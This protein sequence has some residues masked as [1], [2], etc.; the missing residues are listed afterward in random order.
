[1]PIEPLT[2]KYFP[3]F[4]RFAEEAW[5]RAVSD[6][7]YQWRY[8]DAP[9]LITLVANHGGECV[10]S[11]SAFSRTY[12]FGDEPVECLDPFDWYS[13]PSVR[14]SGVG[15]RLIKYLMDVGKPI[16]TL[17]GSADTLQII[18]RLGWKTVSEATEF[19]LPLTSRYLL[20][21]RRLPNHWNRAIAP[22]LDFATATWFMPAKPHGASN[23]VVLPVSG[24]DRNLVHIDGPA[25]FRSVPDPR[26]FDWLMKGSPVTGTYI[27]MALVG[28]QEIVAWI[29]GRL[30]RSGGL[31]HGMILDLRLQ[32]QDEA[33]AESAIKYMARALAGFGADHIRAV[34]TFGLFSAAYRRSGFLAGREKIPVMM[35]PESRKLISEQISVSGTADGA[36]WPL[37]EDMTQQEIH[38]EPLHR[39][40]AG[41]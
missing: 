22:P 26:I 10:S 3:A 36:F 8:F 40:T 4:K 21:N 11:L 18:P 2:R 27:P 16:L 15:V 34:T 13:L 23:C 30:Y 9:D 6:A 28:E 41:N 20:R 25:G 14:G 35:W 37:Q 29:I 38:R 17:G 1:M 5:D 33:L 31:L 12:Q 32:R 7:Y 19:F 39:R 24:I